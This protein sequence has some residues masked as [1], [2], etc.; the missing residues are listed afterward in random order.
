MCKDY[1]KL[2]HFAEKWRV[3]DGKDSIHRPRIKD[4]GSRKINYVE[5]FLDP[6]EH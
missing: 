2:Y 3:Y 4:P 6:G 1:S 5:D